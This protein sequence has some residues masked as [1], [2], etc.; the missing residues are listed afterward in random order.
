MTQQALIILW[1]FAKRLAN[2]SGF[3]RKKTTGLMT[4]GMSKPAAAISE[5]STSPKRMEP[6]F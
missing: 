6:G 2:Q 4:P 3:Q 5:T 1:Q